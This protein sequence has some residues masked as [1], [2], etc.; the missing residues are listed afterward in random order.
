M[1]GRTAAGV[2]I[3]GYALH[4]KFLSIYSRTYPLIYTPSY[5]S[6][7]PQSHLRTHLFTFK[8]TFKHTLKHPSNSSL[9]LLLLLLLLF[10]VFGYT[11]LLIK[12]LGPS[13]F[14][15]I[16]VLLMI[17]PFNTIFLKVP[18]HTIST[19]PINTHY[20]HT[21]STHTINTHYQ[22]T[23]S[24]HPVTHFT[25][26][27]YQHTL[28]T[29]P[30]KS[31]HQNVNNTFYQH[32]LSTHAYQ[33]TESTINRFNNPYTTL[34]H[35]PSHPIPSHP[36]PSH[37]ITPHHTPSHT[38]LKKLSRLKAQCL[39]HTDAR[40]KLTNEI[41]QGVR[42]IKSYNWERAFLE[43]L[44]GQK[45]CHI[46]PRPRSL[47]CPLMRYVTHPLSNF[48]THSRSRLNT[49]SN[50]HPYCTTPQLS[51]KRPGAEGSGGRSEH[52]GYINSRT[53]RW[54]TEHPPIPP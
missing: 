44:T 49:S 53:H 13:V 16:V 25:K 3:H 33:P 47:T 4:I 7:T 17:I 46:L 24:T 8:H 45:Y 39:K 43:K 18:T 41:L 9:L 31:P 42:A 1:L 32:T 30:N 14:A 51:H 38:I 2:R 48:P 15:G 35:T 54:A 10:Q 50:K 12:F 36:T 52:P 5:L 21:L 23:L 28:S 37:P 40:V 26:T 22:H 6:S 34:H 19:H 29:H 20:Q 11:A 27:P